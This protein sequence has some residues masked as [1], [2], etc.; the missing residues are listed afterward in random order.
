MFWNKYSF[1]IFF[2]SSSSYYSLYWYLDFTIHNS[3]FQS[4]FNVLNNFY[5]LRK[6]L[7]D[8]KLFLLVLHFLWFLSLV[9]LF[10]LIKSWTIIHFQNTIMVLSAVLLGWRNKLSDNHIIKQVAQARRTAGF[11]G[12]LFVLFKTPPNTTLL[13]ATPISA[14]KIFRQ[15]SRRRNH[16]ITASNPAYYWSWQYLIHQLLQKKHNLSLSYR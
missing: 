2:L 11:L 4:S 1:L 13:Q 12:A 3:I 15:H 14:I 6:D 10:K 7:E 5:L 16:G 8:F 9:S